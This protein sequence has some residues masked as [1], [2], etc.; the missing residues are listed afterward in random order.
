MA[1]RRW[2]IAG[3][4]RRAPGRSLRRRNAPV[5]GLAWTM[6]CAR[7][8]H[9]LERLVAVT[10]PDNVASGRVLEK[11]GFTFVRM[12]RLQAGAGELK[13]FESIGRSPVDGV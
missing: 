11:L 9:G 7:D 3:L 6:A 10:T 12:I 8:V 5:A 13:L 2:Q 4:V 1:V